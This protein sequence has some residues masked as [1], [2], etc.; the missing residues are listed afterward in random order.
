MAKFLIS[1]M[2]ATGHVYPFLLTAAKLVE[3]GHDVRWHTGPEFAEKVQATGAKFVAMNHTRNVLQATVDAQKKKGLEAANAA[4]VSLFVEPMLGQ[5]KDYQTILADFHADALVVDMCSLGAELLYEKGGPVWAS[6]GINP[7]RTA[8]SPMYGSGQLPATSATGRWKNRMMNKL[9]GV[10]LKATTTTFNEHRQTI[11]LPPIPKDKTVFDYLMS[12][13]LHLQGTTQAF[14]F[15]YR[16]LPQQIHYV[17]PM[18]PPVPT[19][20]VKPA[21]WAELNSGRPVVHITQGT[22]STDIT[23]LVQPTIQALADEDVLVVVTTSET[24]KLGILPANVRVERMIP[25]SVLLPYVDVMVTNGGYNGVKIALA[26]GVPLVGAG[27]TEDKPEVCSRIA[28]SGAGI[29]LKTGSPTPEQ[30]KQAILEV[31]HNPAYR[32][33]ARAIQTDFAA[34]DSPVEAVRLLEGLIRSENPVKLKLGAGNSV[35]FQSLVD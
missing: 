1:T 22:V 3:M 4:M 26:Y 24:K 33:K 15:P 9:S 18:L 20:F 16:D 11:G 25:H 23:E 31:L 21:W 29:N 12:P 7:L 14:E 5:L 19:D 28:W 32:Q 8:E 13:F 6:V 34:H 35:R 27:N 30:L 2:P 17:G 10:F